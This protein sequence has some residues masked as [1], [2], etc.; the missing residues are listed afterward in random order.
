[1]GGMEKKKKVGTKEQ[2][3]LDGGIS[4]TGTALKV[5]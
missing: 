2:H 3:L 4:K 5:S 1:M